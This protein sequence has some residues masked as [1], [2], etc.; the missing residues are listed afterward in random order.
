MGMKR[1]RKKLFS[2]TSH[3]EGTKKVSQEP[4]ERNIK[5][6]IERDSRL[7]G[8][9]KVFYSLVTMKIYINCLIS[10]KSL[11]VFFHF[12]LFLLFA[13]LFYDLTH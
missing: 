2:I 11:K 10:R 3:T 12:L 4:P 6:Q 1:E 5:A 7:F 8:K 9:Q 13:A